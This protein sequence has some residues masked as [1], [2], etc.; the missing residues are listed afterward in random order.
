LTDL[1]TPIRRFFQTYARYSDAGDIPAIVSQFAETFMAANP[2]GAQCVRAADFA[3]A[4]P[5][6]F[7]LFKDLGCES[8]SLVLLAETT[9]D[10]R[11]V[12]AETRWRMT[13]RREH[14]EPVEAL[15]DSLFIV[16]T[17]G[18]SLKIVFYLAH[19][20]YTVMLRKSGLLPS[21]TP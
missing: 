21:S 18:Q 4:L 13:F 16:N 14:Q 8:T 7:Q 17:G 12:M 5:K 15:A 6:R 20:D 1:D 9:L 3:L 2:N 11:F 19:Q 10:N